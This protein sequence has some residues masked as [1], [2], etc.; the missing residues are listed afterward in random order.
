M[1]THSICLSV[2][3]ISLSLI[4]SGYI[5]VFANCRISF[6]LWLS[7][8]PHFI[9]HFIYSFV[10]EC[11]H[12][13]HVLSIV[14]NAAVNTEL[15]V[16]FW[17]NVFT[18]FGYILRNPR[19]RGAWWAAV[20]GVAQSQTWLKRLSSSSS[21]SSSSRVVHREDPLE[22]GMATTSRILAWIILKG[23]G[24]WQAAVHGV[25]KSGTMTEATK[26]VHGGPVSGVLRGLHTVLHSG[27]TNLHSSC[28]YF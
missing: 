5:H 1:I 10:D 11:L 19:D 12:C 17:I 28:G 8:S 16:S 3:F 13:F 25:A 26:H 6:F 4:L 27:C 20:Y 18:S 7:N 9:P 15:H 2:W 14:N 23:R 24:A 21:S 22:V